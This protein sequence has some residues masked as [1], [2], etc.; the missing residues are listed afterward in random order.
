ML[1]APSRQGGCDLDITK[2]MH[3]KKMLAC[4]PLHDRVSVDSLKAQIMDWRS[5]PWTTPIFEL[6]EYFGEKIGL[7]SVF[8]GFY[9]IWLIVPAVIGLVFQLVVWGTVNFSSPVLP[10]YSV[11]VTI[12][13]MVRVSSI[14]PIAYFIVGAI[15][16]SFM[17]F[18][19]QSMLEFWRRENKAVTL[20]WGTSDFESNELDRPE[21]FGESMKSYID[22]SDIIWYPPEQSRRSNRTSRNTVMAFMTIVCGV[23]ACIYV[24]KFQLSQPIG[25]Y[26]SLVASVIN[27]IQITIFNLIYQVMLWSL[28]WKVKYRIFILNLFISTLFVD[29]RHQAHR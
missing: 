22:G 19:S 15:S 10:F 12:W 9:S 13:G 28:I 8:M 11:V 14:H 23:V 24:L 18:S 3:L 2:W 26:A 1:R 21:Y 20:E 7:Y 27:T 5:T 25:S 17:F 6:K 29:N 4:F 16:M